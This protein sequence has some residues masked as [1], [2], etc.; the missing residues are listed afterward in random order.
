LTME[1]FIELEEEDVTL[2][3]IIVDDDTSFRRSLA[4]GL[5]AEGLD[6][7]ELKNGVDLLEFLQDGMKWN[8]IRN[9]I[10]DVRMPGLDGFLLADEVRCNYPSINVIILSAHSYPLME[11]EYTIFSKPVDISKLAR[12]LVQVPV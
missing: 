6:V 11:N 1:N 10:V 12:V 8:F 2:R 9:I 3:T 7:V 4:I 5:E